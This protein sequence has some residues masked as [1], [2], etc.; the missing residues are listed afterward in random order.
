MTYSHSTCVCVHC[1]LGFW[2]VKDLLGLNEMWEF[3]GGV[4]NLPT[5]TLCS[6]LEYWSYGLCIKLKFKNMTAKIVHCSRYL[7]T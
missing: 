4:K 7:I 1:K 6:S 3:G 5:S 2:W